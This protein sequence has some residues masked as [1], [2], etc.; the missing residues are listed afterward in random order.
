MTRAGTRKYVQFKVSH[1]IRQGQGMSVSVTQITVSYE[2]ESDGTFFLKVDWVEDLGAGFTVALCDGES[3]WM[4]EV[5]EEEVTREAEELEMRRERY[6]EE[7]Q[8]AL[9]GGAG[10][11]NGAYAFQL[12]S[13][14]ARRGRARRLTY[15][16]V[17]KDISL[18]LGSV[19]LL[20]CPEPSRVI[21]ELISHGLERSSE[22]WARNQ[23][24]QEENRR[25]GRE[26]DR[27]TAELERYVQGKE[28]LEQE[29]YTRFVLVL[30]EKKARIRGLQER[31]R[32]LQEEQEQGGQRSAPTVDSSAPDPVEA[33]YDAS[34]DEE[35]TPSIQWS[36]VSTVPVMDMTS[37]SEDANLSDLF[38]VAPMRKRR[39]RHLSDPG[40]AASESSQNPQSER[41]DPAHSKAEANRA[42]AQEPP[43]VAMPSPKEVNLFDD[44]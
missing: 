23:H 34:T 20:M 11:P 36:Q 17:Q 5:S 42:A 29:L 22:L 30:N 41:K 37:G 40:S 44:F 14:S 39:W 24:L 27:I 4:G 10:R 25:L 6:V 13:E 26:Q 33:D 38:D 7:L 1:P 12:S 43:D 32:Q 35:Q 19:E 3:A 2:S 28:T 8:L 31:L 9:A 18:R 16:K 15:E 21:K